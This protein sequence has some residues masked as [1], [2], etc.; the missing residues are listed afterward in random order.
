[1]QFY[2]DMK[3][4]SNEFTTVDPNKVYGRNV[5]NIS[6]IP[7]NIRTFDPDFRVSESNQEIWKLAH[8]K[9]ENH[10]SGIYVIH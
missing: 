1:M 8:K 5:D 3:I 2:I 4:R 7:L 10:Q 6:G 9:N